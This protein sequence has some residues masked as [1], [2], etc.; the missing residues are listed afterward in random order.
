ML[1]SIFE[2]GVSDQPDSAGLRHRGQGRFV[3]HTYMAKMGGTIGARNEAGGV[4]FVLGL[5][6][7]AHAGR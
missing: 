3:A 1:E 5:E 4:C 2:Y 6:R 7:A